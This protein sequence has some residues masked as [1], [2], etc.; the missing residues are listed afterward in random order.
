MRYGD[1]RHRWREG[2]Q[3]KSWQF[4][5]AHTSL[6]KTQQDFV[7]RREKVKLLWTSTVTVVSHGRNEGGKV[8]EF[9]TS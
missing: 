1:L 3:K 9:R 8:T 4:D 6:E 2:N 5:Y 7:R